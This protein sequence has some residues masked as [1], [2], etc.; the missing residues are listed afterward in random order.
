[1]STQ[2]AD[3]LR[4]ALAALF[5]VGAFGQL[6]ALVIHWDDLTPRARRV[7]ATASPLLGSLAASAWY[8]VHS[9]FPP[10]PLLPYIVTALFLFDVA[11]IWR[12]PSGR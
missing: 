8:S 3:A 2:T 7:G 12:L 1:M 9:H 5:S 11:V 10:N 4:W 6:F